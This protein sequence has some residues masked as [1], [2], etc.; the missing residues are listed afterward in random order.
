M[1]NTKVWRTSLSPMQ[2]EFYGQFDPPVDS[3]IFTRYAGLLPRD[4]GTYIECGAFDGITESSC[5]FFSKYFNWTGINIEASP[6]IFNKLKNNR[7]DAINL[8]IGLSN[9]LG[10][11]DFTDVHHPE[12]D[13]C[14]NGSLV[15]TKNHK[16]WLDEAK[17]GYST[18]TIETTTY[19][20]L[21]KQLGLSCVDL[22]VLDVEGHEMEVL[23]GITDDETILPKV[24]V[25]EIGHLDI[26]KIREKL[27]RFGYEYDTTRDVNA[28]FVLSATNK[29]Y[30]KDK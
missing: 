20:K 19:S 18:V 16:A 23:Q 7:P 29:T 4:K 27:S 22:M 5:Y 26:H 15:H 6:A 10:K 24:M 12:F 17:C 13:L 25:V 28:Y 1:P 14:T 9:K 8:N 21:I 3:F 30:S 11:S 2:Y